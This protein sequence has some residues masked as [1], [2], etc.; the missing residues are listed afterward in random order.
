MEVGI[1]LP[2]QFVTNPSLAS[3]VVI[4]EK[5]ST[6]YLKPGD[7]LLIER[8]VG[9][10]H[11]LEPFRDEKVVL[12]IPERSDRINYSNVESGRFIAGTVRFGHSPEPLNVGGW[13]WDI[14]PIFSAGFGAILLDAYHLMD[15]DVYGM[16]GVR[17]HS[18]PK[19]EKDPA[20]FI[21]ELAYKQGRL[22]SD[23]KILGRL[24]GWLP[25]PAQNQ[26]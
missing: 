1:S 22:R 7:R 17:S 10:R 4:D 23:S 26:V 14:L 6:D 25:M 3:L 24:I 19:G 8:N 21:Q 2:A 11:R 16:H 12:Q 20:K 5:S 9:D 13:Q 18:I 15:G